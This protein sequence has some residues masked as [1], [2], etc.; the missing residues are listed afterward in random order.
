MTAQGQPN[1]PFNFIQ[2]VIA[3]LGAG[4]LNVIIFFIG[5]ASGASMKVGSNPE[6]VIGFDNILQAT[7]IPLLAFGFI[8]FLIGRAKKGIIKV[9]QWVGLVIAVVSSISAIMTAADVATA[10]TLTV[11]H[12][13]TGA[14][15]F[16]AVHYGNKKLH[17]PA[18]D[19]V[20]A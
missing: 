19:V 16:F 6:K 8:V 9:A 3:A 15:W 13:V 2:V 17:I 11:I 5:I 12:I 4:Y 18:K 1:S 7:W 20:V 14:A 10:V